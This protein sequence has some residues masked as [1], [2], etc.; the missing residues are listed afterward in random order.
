MKRCRTI[1]VSIALTCLAA[2]V[3]AGLVTVDFNSLA[4]GEIATTQIPGLTISAENPNREGFDLAIG[5]DTT[6]TGTEDFDLEG[7]PSRNWSGGN[8]DVTEN[9]GTM[10]ILA[11]NNVD[12]NEDGLIDR[13]DDEGHRPA[14]TLR[15]DFDFAIQAIG[16]DLID[17]EGVGVGEEPGDFATF[18]NGG[19]ALG[20]VQFADFLAGGSHDQGAQFGDHTLNRVAPIGGFGPFNRV[21][22]NLGGSGAV[23]N[24]VYQT[25]APGAA[26]LVALGL[27]ALGVFGNKRR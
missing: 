8:A 3:W 9:V 4:H 24:L 21:D 25:P 18:W 6:V 26:L 19:T 2:P 22:I 16:F 20:T 7:P 11:E 27:A 5:F 23:D 17:I 12:R 10:L 1:A 15:F 14:G 13:P